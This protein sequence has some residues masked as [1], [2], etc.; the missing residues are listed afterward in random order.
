MIAERETADSET[1]GHKFATLRESHQSLVRNFAGHD[2]LAESA[3][4]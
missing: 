1:E 3:V 4:A 2:Q